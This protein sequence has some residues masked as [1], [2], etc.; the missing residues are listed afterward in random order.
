MC[1][2]FSIEVGNLAERRKHGIMGVVNSRV[3]CEAESGVSVGMTT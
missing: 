3:V 1:R 2:F